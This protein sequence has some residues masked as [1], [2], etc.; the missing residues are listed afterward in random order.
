MIIFFFQTP[1]KDFKRLT[2]NQSCGLKHV[3]L[4]ITIQEIIRVGKEFCFSR[5]SDLD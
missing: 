2:P 1:T 5:S 4:I 3:A